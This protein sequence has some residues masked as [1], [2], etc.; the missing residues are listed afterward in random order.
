MEFKMKKINDWEAVETVPNL[1]E[2]LRSMR[3]EY[4]DETYVVEMLEEQLS[5]GSIKRSIRIRLA[6][7]AI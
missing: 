5:D 4:L 1:I 3:E 2:A 7:S 6:E